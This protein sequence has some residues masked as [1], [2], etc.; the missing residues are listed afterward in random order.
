MAQ[1]FQTRKVDTRVWKTEEQ[2]QTAKSQSVQTTTQYVMQVDQYKLGRKQVY[3]H[4]YQT[5]AKIGDDEIGV[6]Q[7]GRLHADSV[8]RPLRGPGCPSRRFEPP[9]RPQH[10]HDRPRRDGRPRA[11]LPEDHL[12][13]RTERAAV[14]PRRELHAGSRSATALNNWVETRCDLVVGNAD[15]L[16]RH[17]RRRSADPGRS[18]SSSTPARV[19]RATTR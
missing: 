17:L 6:P 14:R 9:C 18:R 16:Q 1:T 12:H 13:R 10:L 8:R 7:S 15:A 19:R 11:W 4:Q 5:L 3:R 2:W